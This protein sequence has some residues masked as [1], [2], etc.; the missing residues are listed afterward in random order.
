MQELTDTQLE[1]VAQAVKVTSFQK[2]DAIVNYGDVGEMFY[3][4]KSGTVVCLVPSNES[5]GR[6]GSIPI[7]LHAGAYFGERA[8]IKNEPRAADVISNSDDCVCLTLDKESFNR[9]LGPLED[10]MRCNVAKTLL[11]SV[12]FLK[13]ALTDVTMTK[14]AKISKEVTIAQNEYI[15][16]ADGAVS[17]TFYLIREGNVGVVDD[18]GD[19]TDMLAAGQF[20]A[21]EAVTSPPFVTS[22]SYFA[23]STSCSLFKIDTARF[24]SAI[25]GM[26]WQKFLQNG[27]NSA[28]LSSESMASSTDLTTSDPKKRIMSR[29]YFQR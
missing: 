16:H 29:F 26:S 3:M 9:L 14:I 6:R 18:N 5:G 27:G 25:G 12:P 7:E 4:L 19:I 11:S 28:A 2:G 20:F 23:S 22:T 13:N 1:R 24:E 21:Q 17:R 15:L 10:I 8:L